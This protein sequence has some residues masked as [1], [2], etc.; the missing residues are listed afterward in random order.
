MYLVAKSLRTRIDRLHPNQHLNTSSDPIWNA[1]V[2]NL[3]EKEFQI[4]Y[5]Y[6]L[7]KLILVFSYDCSKRIRQITD[8]MHYFMD[9]IIC[10]TSLSL[11]D[12]STS[13]HSKSGFASR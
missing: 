12:M 10:V 11:D 13:P 1:H 9:Q 5:G 6:I 3:K 7:N 8:Y 2:G 4:N